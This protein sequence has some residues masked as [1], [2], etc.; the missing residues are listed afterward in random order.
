[1]N[2]KENGKHVFLKGV[3]DKNN[4]ECWTVLI[5]VPTQISKVDIWLSDGYTR[6]VM[7]QL[8]LI[9]LGYLES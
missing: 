9:L 7:N 5:W 8:V 3:H 2:S 1:M 6:N 4:S